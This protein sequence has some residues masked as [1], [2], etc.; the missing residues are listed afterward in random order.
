MREGQPANGDVCR[1][2][3]SNYRKRHRATSLEAAE[4]ADSEV[5][6]HTLKDLTTYSP[7]RGEPDVTSPGPVRGLS[8]RF[9]QLSAPMK[10]QL[11]L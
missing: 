10:L 7:S 4:I 6:S 11:F 1:L 9:L 5:G 2:D 8:P 3:K